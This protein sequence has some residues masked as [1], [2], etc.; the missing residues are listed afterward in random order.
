MDSRGRSGLL[1][2]V[3][4]AL[5]AGCAGAQSPIVSPPGA[6]AQS[7]RSSTSSY[8]VLYS[9]DRFPNGAHPLAGLTAYKG[10]L[11]G[12]TSEGGTKGCHGKPGCGAVFGITTSGAEHLLY[13]FATTQQGR[14]PESSLID[15]NGTLYGTTEKGGGGAGTIYSVSP[16]GTETVVHSFR[17]GTTDGSSPIA[18]LTVVKGLFYGTTQYGGKKKSGTVY[19]V[20]TSGAVTLL[21][22]FRGTPDGSFPTGGLIDVKGTLYGTT[23]FGGS[24]SCNYG[25]GTVYSIT[26][27]GVEN[28]LYSFAGGSDGARP[29]GDLVF[30]NGMLYGT[31]SGGGTATYGTVYS[32]TTSGKEKVLYSFAGG[33]D[34]RSPEKG[35]INVNGTLYGT[36]NVGGNSGCFGDYGCGTIYSI[37]TAGAESVLYSFPGGTDGMSPNGPLLDVNGLLY[38]TTIVGGHTRSDCCGTVFAFTP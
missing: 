14:F 38:G 2:G 7:H 5:L 31:T 17:G 3:A 37:S 29:T 4:A 23:F 24:G 21:H 10:M 35:L 33:S 36:T 34:G 12:S 19:S 32:I 16:S 25:C 22:S 15:V 26:P 11:Y 9:F 30:V 1:A 28:V 18:G 6:I 27:D 20:S 8:R 13:S